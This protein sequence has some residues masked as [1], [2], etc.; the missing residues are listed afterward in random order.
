M[1]V[2][3]F[4]G[5]E[6]FCNISEN[7]QPFFAQK[8]GKTPSQQHVLNSLMKSITYNTNCALL[9]SKKISTHV[10]LFNEI[11]ELQKLHNIGEYT[12]HAV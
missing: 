12:G 4:A 5:Y 7:L 6:N 2:Q 1:L 9:I 11:N 10:E 3:G 8:F